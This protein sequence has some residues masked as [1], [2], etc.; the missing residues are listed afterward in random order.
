MEEE[1]ELIRGVEVARPVHR[2][3]AGVAKPRGRPV[4]FALPYSPALPASVLTMPAFTKARKRP[5]VISH[6]S[7]AKSLTVAGKLLSLKVTPP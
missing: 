7:S 1:V 5:T 3:A 2:H 6:L 4:P